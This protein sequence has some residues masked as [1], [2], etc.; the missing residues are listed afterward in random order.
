MQA[1]SPWMLD[2]F[3]DSLYNW[4]ITLMTYRYYFYK[5]L[6]RKIVLSHICQILRLTIKILNNIQYQFKHTWLPRSVIPTELEQ[7]VGPCD[8]P[9][10]TRIKTL[11]WTQNKLTPRFLTPCHHITIS[12]CHHVISINIF[13]SYF[14]M[15]KLNSWRCQHFGDV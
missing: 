8:V 7:I 15:S 2:M 11:D 9:L 3:N 4:Q 12:P 5:C 6:D 13:I 10:L 14:I 1:T